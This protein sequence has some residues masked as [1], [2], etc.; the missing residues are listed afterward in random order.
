MVQLDGLRGIAVTLVLFHHWTSWGFNAGLGNLGVQ[1]FFVISG[2]L[3]TG[4]LLDERVRL[5][6]GQ[7]RLGRALKNFHFN[8][9]ARLWPIYFLTLA[10]VALAGTRFAP[11][12]DLVWHALF[13]SNFLFLTKGEF[14]GDLSHFWT[15]AVEQQ[16]YLFWPL[17]VLF[18][19]PRRLEPITVLLVLLAPLLRWALYLSGLHNFAEF[20]TLPFANT[21]SLCMG[22]LIA[23][24]HRFDP[25]CAEVRYKLLS[26]A[27]VAAAVILVLIRATGP[28][29]EVFEQS[30]YAVAFAWIVMGASTGI[31]GLAG[32]VL[33]FPPL[34][35]IGLVSYGIYIY[36]MFMPRVVGSA[37]RTF[38]APDAV[39]SGPIFFILCAI[40]T[41][42]LATMSWMMVEKPVIN[43]RRSLRLRRSARTS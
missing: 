8:R 4:I 19:P 13:A 26:G 16:F 12:Q 29:L 18:V 39:Q 20:N 32:R 6:E 11:P 43:W 15:L 9:V 7:Q 36:H 14:G 27:A 37:L 28:S 30:L 25:N 41:I 23:Q 24:W 33:S 1:L 22:A 31:R 21:D 2:F 5:S 38:A 35:W 10:A 34:L 40:S 17:V 3:I 42:I